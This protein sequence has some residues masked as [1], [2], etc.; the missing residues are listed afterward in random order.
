[1]LKRAARL[2]RVLGTAGKS[3]QRELQSAAFDQRRL[4]DKRGWAHVDPN[5]DDADF[6]VFPRERNGRHYNLNWAINAY[7]VLSFSLSLSLSL[8]FLSILFSSLF[9]IK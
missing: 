7:R 6:W 5:E 9:I 3:Q 4:R 1:M 2:H 8:S